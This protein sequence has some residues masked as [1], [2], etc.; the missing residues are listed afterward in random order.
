M[1]CALRPTQRDADIDAGLCA[2]WPRLLL[3]LGALVSVLAGAPALAGAATTRT[4]KAV[5]DGEVQA[6]AASSSF[7]GRS[8]MRADQSPRRLAYLRFATTRVAGAVTSAKLRLYVADPSIDGPEGFS[9]ARDWAEAGLTFRHKPGRSGP[10]LGDKG[11]V[12]RG[13]VEYDVTAAVAAGDTVIGFVLSGTSTDGLTIVTRE[14]GRAPELRITTSAPSSP[15][16]APQAGMPAAA[17][18]AAAATVPAQAAATTPTAPA[19]P[20]APA[21]PSASAT[22]S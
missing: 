11:A 22:P 12:G 4:V 21:T 20:S 18:P 6:Y 15:A 14:G 5:A 7:G 13:W 3:L 1:A 8:F 16:P 17:S 19:I 10:A 2:R 9:T